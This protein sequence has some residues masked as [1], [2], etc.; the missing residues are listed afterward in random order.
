[1]VHAWS[2]VQV[3]DWNNYVLKD[4]TVTIEPETHCKVDN[5][6]PEN[7][8]DAVNIHRIIEINWQSVIVG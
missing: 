3:L 8:F 1:M 5:W 4:L 7:I 2:F 6:A